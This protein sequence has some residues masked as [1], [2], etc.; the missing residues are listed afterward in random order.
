MAYR[1]IAKR[2]VI[3]ILAALFVLLSSQAFSD[4]AQAQTAPEV[5]GPPIWL[6]QDSDGFLME[7]VW[8]PDGSQLVVT[9][10]KYRGLWLV[11]TESQTVRQVTDA[12]AVGY[13]VSWS[14]GGEA[15]LGRVAR[16]TDMRRSDAVTVFDLATGESQ[17]LSEF[18]RSMPHIPQWTRDG[19][20]A[21]VRDGQIELFD[22]ALTAPQA[23][24]DDSDAQNT[25]SSALYFSTEQGIGRARLNASELQ[26]SGAIETRELDADTINPFADRQLLN[27]TP[28]PDGSMIAFEVMGGDLY[29]MQEDGSNVR[30]LGR[31]YRA[32]WSP[33]GEWVAFQRTEDDGHQILSADLFAAHVD[34]NRTV[35]LTQTTDRLEMNPDWSPDGRAIA[36]D[37]DGRIGLLPLSD[38]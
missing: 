6:T 3:P 15:L 11:G 16:Y 12:H 38:D 23:D 25:Q 21:L 7:P 35:Q 31:G 17:H 36:F 28:S 1:S 29:V 37:A 32:T 19:N 8:S 4:A 20:V 33:D 27:V 22:V 5:N 14:P 30:S 26:V 10:S 13:G 9:S 18:R 2:S 24:T 34:G